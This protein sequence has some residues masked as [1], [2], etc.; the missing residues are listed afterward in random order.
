MILQRRFHKIYSVL[1]LKFFALCNCLK[2]QEKT[3]RLKLFNH[4][5]VQFNL[6]IALPIAYIACLFEANN[7]QNY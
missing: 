6:P 7:R 5:Y 4:D 2:F 3:S 1:F